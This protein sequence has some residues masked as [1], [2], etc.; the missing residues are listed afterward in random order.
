VKD[1]RDG[2]TK[3]GI[4]KK[5]EGKRKD[6]GGMEIAGTQYNQC[7]KKRKI[8]RDFDTTDR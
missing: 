7:D 4:K 1:G 8:K 6:K 3:N 2:K 5:N